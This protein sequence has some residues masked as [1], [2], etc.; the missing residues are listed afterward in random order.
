[1]NGSE[2]PQML[3]AEPASQNDLEGGSKTARFL[4]PD[5]LICLDGQIK[6]GHVAC[7]KS[8]RRANHF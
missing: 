7:G 3:I 8:T 6:S 1:M 2:P 5:Q 4:E